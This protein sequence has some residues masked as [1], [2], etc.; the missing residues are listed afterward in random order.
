MGRLI[1]APGAD[2]R[3]EELAGEMQE[4]EGAARL[5]DAP[6]QPHANRVAGVGRGSGHATPNDVEALRLEPKCRLGKIHSRNESTRN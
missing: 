5:S 1:L 4:Q 3:A 2:A 6:A